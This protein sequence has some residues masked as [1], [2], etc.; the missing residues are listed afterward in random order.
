LRGCY[1][2]S[3]AAFRNEYFDGELIP[4]LSVS[5]NSRLSI[6][7]CAIGGQPWTAENGRYNLVVDDTSRVVVSDGCRANRKLPTSEQSTGYVV[8]KRHDYD[9]MPPANM[10]IT[11]TGPNPLNYAGHDGE[12][13]TM[14]DGITYQYD[15]AGAAW[16]SVVYDITPPAAWTQYYLLQDRFATIQKSL[17]LEQDNLGT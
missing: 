11:N 17:S 8:G 1:F 9:L 3:S 7:Y 4:Q 16:N 2:E 14:L 12:R 15:E 13:I 10:A 5:V 6:E